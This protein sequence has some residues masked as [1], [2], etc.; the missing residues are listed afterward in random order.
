MT[1]PHQPEAMESAFAICKELECSIVSWGSKDFLVEIRSANQLEELKGRLAPLGFER[2]PSEEDEQGGVYE[3]GVC[4]ERHQ[5]S[6]FQN[7][8]VILAPLGVRIVPLFVASFFL[9]LC[10][11]AVFQKEGYLSHSHWFN[12]VSLLLAAASVYSSVTA[13]FWKV[14]FSKESL[15]LKSIYSKKIIAWNSIASVSEAPAPVGRF[16]VNVIFKLHDGTEI[17]TRSF[18]FKFARQLRSES[19]R[20]LELKQQ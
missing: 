17:K 16:L 1:K 19:K 10:L 6:P 7:Q 13:H 11:W 12:A 14:E 2:L 9:A 15:N 20:R 4:R 8:P 18:H 5:F 3:F